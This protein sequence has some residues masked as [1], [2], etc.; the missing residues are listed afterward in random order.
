M[1]AKIPFAEDQTETRMDTD[2]MAPLV[3]WYSS[4][5]IVETSGSKGVGITPITVSISIVWLIGKYLTS[6]NSSDKKGTM[7]KIRKNAACAE[8][9]LILS[10]F[11]RLLNPFIIKYIS[12]INLKSPYLMYLTLVYLLCVKDM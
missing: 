6:V 3:F 5:N 10:S 4:F 1:I 11:S 2:R 9:A 8:K 7:D 12:E